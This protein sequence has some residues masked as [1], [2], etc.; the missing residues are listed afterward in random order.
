MPMPAHDR[1]H[2][3]TPAI[4]SVGQVGTGCAGFPDIDDEKFGI[5]M[6]VAYAPT[7]AIFRGRGARRP[8]GITSAGCGDPCEATEVVVAEGK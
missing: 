3:R 1:D 5:R 7:L 4:E 8:I 2:G 6:F